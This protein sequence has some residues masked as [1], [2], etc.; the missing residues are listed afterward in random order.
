[1]NRS[2]Y[3]EREIPLLVINKVKTLTPA[4]ISIL[5]LISKSKVT[6]IKQL[7]E[8]IDEAGRKYMGGLSENCG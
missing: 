8:K 1:M 2:F 5:V 3:I 4:R 6:N 7:L